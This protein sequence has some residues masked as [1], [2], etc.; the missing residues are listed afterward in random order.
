MVKRPSIAHRSSTEALMPVGPKRWRR[1]SRRHRC[2]RVASAGAKSSEVCRVHVSI[3]TDAQ[4]SRTAVRVVPC[5]VQVTV[6]LRVSNRL[7]FSEP[8]RKVCVFR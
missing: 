6:T 7:G 1:E 8:A 2:L 4:R 3:A 5:S